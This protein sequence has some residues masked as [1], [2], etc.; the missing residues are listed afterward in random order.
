MTISRKMS[1]YHVKQVLKYQ[2]AAK[3]FFEKRKFTYVRRRG[4]RKSFYFEV[5]I[6]DKTYLVRISDHENF[7]VSSEKVAPHFN[8]VN[9]KT[10]CDMKKYFKK[11]Y[12]YGDNVYE[13]QET[14]F[15]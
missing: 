5:S 12:G 7:I 4:S 1:T 15:D 14:K 11:I 8:V 2:E 13:Q 9:G 6:N 10:F 3:L